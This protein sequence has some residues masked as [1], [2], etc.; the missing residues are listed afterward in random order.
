MCRCV[1]FFAFLLMLLLP[2]GASAQSYQAAEAAFQR[3]PAQERH[4][5][6]IM[7]A[8]LGHYNGLATGEFNRRLHQS[9]VSY[10][11]ESGSDA[12]GILTTEQHEKLKLAGAQVLVG[13]GLKEVVHPSANAKLF[14]PLKIVETQNRT[15]RGLAYEG[16]AAAVDF[17]HYAPA[18]ASYSEL[19][20][21]LS[22]V[23]PNRQITYKVFRDQFFIVAGSYNGREFYSRFQPNGASGATGFTLSWDASQLAVGDRLAVLMSNLLAVGF[24]VE[25]STKLEPSSTPAPST[26]PAR[27]ERQQAPGNSSGTAFFVTTTGA[28][29]T[30]AHVIDNCGSMWV[31]TGGGSSLPARVVRKDSTNDLALIQVDTKVDIAAQFRSSI[32]LGEWVGVFGFPLH[33]LITRSGNF[34]QGNVTATA[35]L[36]DDSRMLQISAPVQPGNSG[37]PVLDQS[38]NVVGVVVAKLNATRVAEIAKDIPQNVNFA[39]KA[40]VATNFLESAGIQ[41]QPVDNAPQLSV[42]D[43]ADK[44]KSITAYVE[45]RN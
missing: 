8:A 37:G 17:S 5:I 11:R 7:L 38:G 2:V 9:I 45:C 41:T 20:S 13:F 6:A 39:L 1:R 42:P 21:R 15:A 18:D 3:M 36:L 4:M 27:S 34:T 19:Y 16:N 40:N 25:A 22:L 14:V 43:V 33:G 35:G 10:Q 28:L 29:I 12:T 44:A 24:P 26:P 31:S 23:G 30:N 32:R